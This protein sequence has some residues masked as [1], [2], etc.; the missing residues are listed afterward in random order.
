M[1]RVE[2]MIYGFCTN[3][4]SLDDICTRLYSLAKERPEYICDKSEIWLSQAR[5]CIAAADTLLSHCANDAAIG[6]E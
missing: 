6:G 2:R 5:Q 4:W 3:D 1:G